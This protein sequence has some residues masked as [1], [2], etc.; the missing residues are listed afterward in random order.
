[1]RLEVEVRRHFNSNDG[2]RCIHTRNQSLQQFIRHL[3]VHHGMSP[4]RRK[5]APDT[6]ARCNLHEGKDITLILVPIL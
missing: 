2:V 1:M 5:I 4:W 6:C 3:Q